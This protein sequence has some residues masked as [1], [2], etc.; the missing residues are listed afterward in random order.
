[1]KKGIMIKRTQGCPQQAADIPALLDKE[2]VEWIPMSEHNWADRYPYKPAVSFR[3]AHCGDALL[4]HFRVEEDC[5]RALAE[6]NNGRTWEDSCCELFILPDNGNV[7]YNIEC[8]CTGS[9]RIGCGEKRPNREHATTEVLE[10]ID[11]WS[12]LGV[13]TIP[14]QEGAFQWELALLMPAPAFFRSNISSFNGLHAHLNLYKCGDLLSRPHYLS[15][16]PVGTPDPDFHQPP[17]FGE[18]RFE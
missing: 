10:S 13:D 4:L 5:I 18:A 1:M 11:R 9:L 17:F 8:N 6:R 3:M 12:S 7:Y 16:M 15:W 14:L 2:R